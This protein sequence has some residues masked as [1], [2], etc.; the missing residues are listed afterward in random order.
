MSALLRNSL[1][2]M[3]SAALTAAIGFAFWGVVAHLY[4][5]DRIGLATSLLSALS[6]ISYLALFGFNS[7]LI[8]FP[9]AQ[10]AR[11]TQITVALLGVTVTGALIGAA[12]LL[13]LG[14]ISPA[15]EFI[16][17]DPLEALAFVAFCVLASVNLL[18][19]AV[20]IGARVPQYNTLVDGVIQSLGKL[21][22]PVFLVGLGAAGIVTA[23]GIGYLVA[24]LA[25][26]YFMHRKLG[27]R[28]DLRAKATRLRE[29]A[30]YSISSYASSLLNLLPLLVLPTVALRT[31]GPTQA[32]YYYM[33]FQIA[34]L[35]SATSYAI[36][37]SLFSEGAHDPE[38]FRPLLR[39]S[40]KIMAL[41][42]VPGGAAVA[43]LGKPVLEIFGA[44]YAAN[45]RQ[46]LV[47]LSLG[48]VTVAFNAWAANALRIVNR[49]RS[50]VVSDIV[51]TGTVLGLATG[52][53]SRG[54]IWFGYA[55]VAGNLAAGS[56]AAARIPRRTP[57]HRRT[58][59]RTPRDGLMLE[60]PLGRLDAEPGGMP[61]QGEAGPHAEPSGGVELGPA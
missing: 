35:L 30:R 34:T 13:G 12:Y 52:L 38:N 48:S 58:R 21:A 31:L 4:P 41:V 7:T 3:L 28:F 39:R 36:G 16:R 24:V 2:L 57:A 9:A 50:L 20:F 11:N 44:G 33:A 17:A 1:F 32:A 46:L 53:G 18:T 23:T 61:E 59:K 22:M 6:L 37:Q 56:V 10:D 47:V 8:R 40:A 55:W 51:F 25:S 15:L 5:A 29:S 45:A 49:M 26:L 60:T 42:A 27:F 19:D 54:L 14:L 43:A